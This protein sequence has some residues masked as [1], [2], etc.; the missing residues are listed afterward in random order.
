MKRENAQERRGETAVKNTG[1]QALHWQRTANEF[2]EVSKTVDSPEMLQGWIA[3][4][5]QLGIPCLV[6]KRRS[7]Y[8]LWRKG[9][10]AG[11]DES[12]RP[13]IPE[14]GKIVFAYGV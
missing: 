12:K 1:P 8:S 5:R 13:A 11:I 14:T 4:F 6:V 10:E 3:W 2:F 7:G 9:R